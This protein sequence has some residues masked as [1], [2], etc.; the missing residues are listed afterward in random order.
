M[1]MICKRNYNSFE[2]HTVCE[3]CPYSEFFWP[4][5]SHIRTEYGEI[6]RISLYSVRMWENTD[7][8]KFEYGHFSRSAINQFLTTG[9]FLYLLENIRKLLFF[10]AFRGYT[11]WTSGL[12]WISNTFSYLSIYLRSD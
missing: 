8:K 10:D 11:N 2:T 5:F 1:G 9:L 3:R 6:L 7:Q 4:V 12:K